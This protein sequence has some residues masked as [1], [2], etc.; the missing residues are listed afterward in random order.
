MLI[1]VLLWA[2]SECSTKKLKMASVLLHFHTYLAEVSKCS[3][4][5][6]LFVSVLT[7]KNEVDICSTISNMGSMCSTMNVLHDLHKMTF[8]LLRF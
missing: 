4:N 8:V 2:V 7:C 6:P 1:N 3:N 5:A